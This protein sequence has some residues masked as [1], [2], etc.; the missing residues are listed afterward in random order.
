[1]ADTQIQIIGYPDFSIIGSID[2]DIALLNMSYD[3]PQLMLLDKNCNIKEIIDMNNEEDT[4][5]V[6]LDGREFYVNDWW[7]GKEKPSFVKEI[8]FIKYSGDKDGSHLAS[9][10]NF[11][12]QFTNILNEYYGM[13]KWNGIEIHLFW[14]LYLVTVGN[15]VIDYLNDD[16]SNYQIGDACTLIYIINDKDLIIFNGGDVDSIIIIKIDKFLKPKVPFSLE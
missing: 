15:K 11:P 14:G 3:E 2:Q 16:E 9:F 10:D 7:E 8:E 5:Y 6:A 13:C 12:Q 1:M 4:P